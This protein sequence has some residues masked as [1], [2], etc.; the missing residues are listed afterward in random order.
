MWL[1]DLGT[2]LQTLIGLV[3][4]QNG[5]LREL[6]QFHTRK[7]AQTP[8]TETSHRPAIRPLGPPRTAKDIFTQT[9]QMD[10]EQERREQE[11]I[12]APWRTPDT[13]SD[14]SGKTTASPT[15]DPVL[16]TFTDFIPPGNGS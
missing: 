7:P 15:A 13:P 10:R 1:R 4:E 6:V 16:D 12:T 9:S 11:R 8:L 14:T 5:L 2:N 3:R